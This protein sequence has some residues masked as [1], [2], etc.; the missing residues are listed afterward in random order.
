LKEIT[1]AKFAFS[2]GYVVLRSTNSDGRLG[3]DKQMPLAIAETI[4]FP[5]IER[6]EKRRKIERKLSARCP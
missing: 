5:R 6:E 1:A 3:R 2:N 4:A